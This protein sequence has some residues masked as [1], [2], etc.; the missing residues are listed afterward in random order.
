M[1]GAPSKQVLPRSL[2]PRKFA[3]QNASLVGLVPNQELVRL[4]AAV[5]GLAGPIEASIDFRIDDSGKAIATGSIKASV[6]Q[7]CQRCLE[8]V[9]Q[10]LT[11][12]LCLALVRSDEES[13]QLDKVF[14]PWLVDTEDGST[15]FYTLVEDE[16]LLALPMV[17]LHEDLCIDESLLQ[18]RDRTRE[19]QGQEGADN[20]FKI[21]A[22]LKNS[23]P[24]KKD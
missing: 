11:V 12:D 18:S 10:I 24:N 17:A 1:P 13:R 22:Q 7:I 20:P 14:D 4:G 23:S 2:N 21:L 6:T 3:Y 19:K 8:E 9:S 15:S 16:L 5:A